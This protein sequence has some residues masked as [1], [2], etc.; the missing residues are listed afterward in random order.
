M[1][2]KSSQERMEKALLSDK[3]S[4][5]KL[6]RRRNYLLTKGETKIEKKDNNYEK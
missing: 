4:T 2:D 3:S 5:N 6:L 1:I